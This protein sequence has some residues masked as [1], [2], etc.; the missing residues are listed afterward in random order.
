MDC[1]SAV[2]TPITTPPPP[3]AAV[4]AAVGVEDTVLPALRSRPD[5]AG[6]GAPDGGVDAYV[7]SGDTIG[8]CPL[9]VFALFTWGVFL[10]YGW[11]R[12]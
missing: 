11:R 3:P 12:R 2:T 8:E 4:N 1:G 6:G 7:V 10:W 5:M 9:I